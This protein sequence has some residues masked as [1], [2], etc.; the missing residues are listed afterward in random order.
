MAGNWIIL[1]CVLVSLLAT[2]LLLIAVHSL[3]REKRQSFVNSFVLANRALGEVRA[4]PMHTC[5]EPCSCYRKNIP[6]RAY[7][8]AHAHE[9]VRAH[10][11][12]G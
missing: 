1:E 5:M 9:H 6:A 12:S 4:M 2:L 3:W 11:H 10:A 7:V 8:H